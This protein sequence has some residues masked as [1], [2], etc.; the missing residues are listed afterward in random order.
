VGHRLGRRE[1]CPKKYHFFGKIKIG[2]SQKSNKISTSEQEAQ[3][4]QAEFVFTQTKFVFA[5]FPQNVAGRFLGK[6]DSGNCARSVCVRPDRNIGSNFRKTTFFFDALKF[7]KIRITGLCDHYFQ[8]ILVPI[9]RLNPP[10]F[11]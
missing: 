1:I 4:A 3:E 10:S 9:L 6:L 7:D 5:N 2:F 8:P 11:V